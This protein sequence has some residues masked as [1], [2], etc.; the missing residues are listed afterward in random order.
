LAGEPTRGTSAREFALGAGLMFV[1]SGG[2]ALFGQLHSAFAF[3]AFGVALLAF[4]L[5][6]TP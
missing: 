1:V 3:F 2:F 6:R 5:M 4:R